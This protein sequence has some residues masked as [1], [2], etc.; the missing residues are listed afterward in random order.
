MVNGRLPSRRRRAPPAGHHGWHER[1]IFPTARAFGGIAANLNQIL[2]ARIL[3]KY[4][5]D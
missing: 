2:I 3:R 1:R 4:A 5:L